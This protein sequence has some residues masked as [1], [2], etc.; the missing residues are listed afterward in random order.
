MA[1][2][3]DSVFQECGEHP[4]PVKKLGSTPGEPYGFLPA[5]IIGPPQ[6]K[7]GHFQISQSAIL[8]TIKPRDMSLSV[9][10]VSIEESP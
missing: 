3:N 9:S 5:S 2:V 1:E 6:W 8:R 10:A 7:Y 4:A